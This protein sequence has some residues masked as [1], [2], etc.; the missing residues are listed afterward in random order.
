VNK[1]I[2]AVK[3]TDTAPPRH[4]RTHPVYAGARSRSSAR[5][6][7]NLRVLRDWI[8]ISAAFEGGLTTPGG[9]ASRLARPHPRP[10]AVY[11]F[12]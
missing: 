9:L 3:D 10:Q 1:A 11:F 6:F 8:W 7:E 5:A 12:Q 4:P 2:D